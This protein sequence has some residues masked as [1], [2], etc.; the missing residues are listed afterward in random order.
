MKITQH[1]E[2]SM[3]KRLNG[4]EAAEVVWIKVFEI[5]SQVAHDKYFH[6]FEKAYNVHQTA[7]DSLKN[8]VIFFREALGTDEWN[9]DE[10]R[11]DNRTFEIAIKRCEH[12]VLEITD[13]LNELPARIRQYIVLQE[14]DGRNID[15][16]YIPKCVDLN[17]CICEALEAPYTRSCLSFRDLFVAQKV[18]V[19]QQAILYAEGLHW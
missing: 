6:E 7:L 3:K 13:Q 12:K 5:F 8:R 10:E 11:P 17:M 2:S 19:Q 4:E 16:F 1:K 14:N 9:F 15:E 18:T